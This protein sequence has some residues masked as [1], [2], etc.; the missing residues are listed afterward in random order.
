MQ[1]TEKNMKINRAAL[2]TFRERRGFTQQQLAEKIGCTKDTVSRWERGMSQKVRSHLR[3]PLCDALDVKW[4]ALT[5]EKEFSRSSSVKVEID[6]GCKNSLEVVADRFNVRPRDILEISSLLFIVVAELSLR[7]RQDRLQRVNQAW[8]DLKQNL[9]NEDGHLGMECFSIQ[10][11]LAED[12]YFGEKKSIEAR[13]LLGR[14]IEAGEAEHLIDGDGPF[15]HYIRK[16][17]KQLPMETASSVDSSD[18]YM[19]DE[20]KVAEDTMKDITGLSADDEIQ[21]KALSFIYSGYIDLADVKSNKCNED[22]LE[23]IESEVTRVQ[24][25]SNKWESEL[26]ES[27]M[28]KSGGN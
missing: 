13:D 18:G 28:D 22:Y 6:L 8:D 4:S 11:P 14:S 1:T 26:L 23:W 25:E 9:S 24:S 7:D 15:V 16:L 10:H 20:Y 5:E 17:I 3:K 27:L 12:L 2:R 21:G 19:I